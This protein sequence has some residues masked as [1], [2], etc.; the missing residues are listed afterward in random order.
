MA[1]QEDDSNVEPESNG[2]VK[3][4]STHAE[5]VDVRHV[6]R[7]ELDNRSDDGV[8]DGASRCEVVEG[9]QGV[10]LEFGRA[11]QA[12]NHNQTDRLEDGREELA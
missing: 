1:Y 2:G 3:E 7:G 8:H 9:N 12:L 5:L 6:Q 4:Q 11:E 10:H